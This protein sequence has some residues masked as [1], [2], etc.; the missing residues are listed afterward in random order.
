MWLLGIELRTSGR[1]ISPAII[2]FLKIPLL[3]GAQQ[4][5]MGCPLMEHTP[6]PVFAFVLYTFIL[7]SIKKGTRAGQCNTPVILASSKF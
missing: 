3:C 4:E 1:A 6:M 5:R 2:N 7:W